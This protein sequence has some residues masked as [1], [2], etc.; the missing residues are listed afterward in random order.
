M[1]K[2]PEPTT[3][4]YIG[5]WI[6]AAFLSNIL[7][8]LSDLILSDMLVK[9]ANDLTF[10]FIMNSLASI[11]IVSGCFIVIYNLFNSLNIKKVMIYIYS[12]G[13]F[14][15]ILNLFVTSQSFSSLNLNVNLN[16][17]YISSII[18]FLVSVYIIRGYFIKKPNR[19]Y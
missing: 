19:W 6:I 2:K 16:I 12:I 3:L 9:G 15:T 17:Y 8:K 5:A 18:S 7:Q 11:I 1:N 14:G 13:G 10:Y 4:K